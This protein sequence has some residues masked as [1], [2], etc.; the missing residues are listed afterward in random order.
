MRKSHYTKN[1][2]FKKSWT[3][4]E[5]KILKKY[6]EILGSSYCLEYLKNRTI[7]QITAKANRLGLIRENNKRFKVNGQYNKQAV[8]SRVSSIGMKKIK[9]F[10]CG[11]EKPFNNN[12]FSYRSRINKDGKKGLKTTCKEC[13]SK[14][15]QELRGTTI[16]F[17]SGTYSGIKSRQ[18]KLNFPRTYL[19]DLYLKQNKKCIY[20]NLKMTHKTNNGRVMTNISVDKK[21]PKKGYSKNNIQLVCF[22]ANIAKQ[23][24]SEELF[25]NFCKLVTSNEHGNKYK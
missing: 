2:V 25:I 23:D 6:Y 3:N 5:I 15:C 7:S 12:F 11:V 4:K 14:R 18:K 22:W 10:I 24:L 19:Y 13:D 17:L 20:T 9:C 16:R 8:N 21:D 1:N